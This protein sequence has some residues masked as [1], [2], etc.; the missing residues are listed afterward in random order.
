MAAAV[1]TIFLGLKAAGRA[2]ERASTA[3]ALPQSGVGAAPPPAAA[4][5]VVRPS[6]LQGSPQPVPSGVAPGARTRARTHRGFKNGVRGH[7]LRLR[8]V[9]RSRLPFRARSKKTKTMRLPKSRSRLLS[10]PFSPCGAALPKAH[11]SDAGITP[12]KADVWTFFGERIGL[13]LNRKS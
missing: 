4:F 5:A 3:W 1:Q 9:R 12:F 13:G 8:A 7:C 6:A 2:S 10:S 11:Y